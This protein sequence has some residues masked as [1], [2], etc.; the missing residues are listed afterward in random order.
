VSNNADQNGTSCEMLKHFEE[1][2]KLVNTT[3]VMSDR[4]KDLQKNVGNLN[5]LPVIADEIRMIRTTLVNAA[6]GKHHIPITAMLPVIGAMA[7]CI[8]ILGGLLFSFH[9]GDKDLKISPSSI[10]MR[11]HDNR[12]NKTINGDGDTGDTAIRG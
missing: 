8:A 10:E 11:Q 6:T 5:S 4:V 1:F 9:S 7:F 3:S 2:S 12:T